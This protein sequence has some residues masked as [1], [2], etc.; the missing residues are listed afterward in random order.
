MSLS[1]DNL[2]VE[3]ES[4]KARKTLRKQLVTI[5]TL[6]SANPSLSFPKIARNPS[7]LNQ[8]YRFV[9]HGDVDPALI[10]EPHFKNTVERKGVRE[11]LALHDTTDLVFGGDREDL[12]Y[13]NTDLNGFKAHVSLLVSADGFREP[14]GVLGLQTI[15]RPEKK[16]PT[17]AARRKS[18]TPAKRLL[19]PNRE[20]ERWWRGIQE[21]EKAAQHPKSIIHIGDAET[22]NYALFARAV[23]AGHRFVFRNSQDRSIESQYS[24][25]TRLS[26]LKKLTSK[27]LELEVPISKRVQKGG[28]AHKRRHPSRSARIATLQYA[29]ENIVILRPLVQDK[30]LPKSVRVNVIHVWEVAAPEGEK[31]IEWM[32]MTTEE[33]ASA[34]QIE[35]VIDWYRTRWMI[36]E[37]FKGLKSICKM[38]ERQLRTFHSLQNVLAILLPCVWHILL[39][40]HRE[41]NAPDSPAADV[42]NPTQVAVLENM[43]V[44]KLKSGATIKEALL[45]IAAWGGHLPQNGPPGWQTLFAGYQRMQEAAL[46]WEQ[47]IR[48][49]SSKKLINH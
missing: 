16:P 6:V 30:K 3:F 20:S 49:M 21:V 12:G 28:P 10:L 4:V 8:I 17:R 46:V 18:Q 7:K 43:P 31:P 35:K 15:N 25:V 42:L 38:E 48:Q 24:D 29:A 40:R 32:L 26:E 23:E 37:F 22:D 34:S 2:A 45:I 5:G 1:S 36:E 19:D 39:L 9:G 27:I 11:A 47:A 41:R 44:K 33:I 13:L 14:L